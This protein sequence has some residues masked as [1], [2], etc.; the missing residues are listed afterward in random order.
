VGDR[1]ALLEAGRDGRGL[2][3]RA[4]PFELHDVA[5]FGLDQALAA[6]CYGAAQVRVVT[7]ADLPDGYRQAL[8]EQL[9]LGNLILR[10]LGYGEQRLGLVDGGAIGD[11]LWALP[12]AVDI[13]AAGFVFPFEKRAALDMALGHLAAAAPAPASEPIALPP[14]SP[15]GTI[16]VDAARCTLCMSCVGA[17]PTGALLDTPEEPKLRFVERNCVQCGLCAQTCPE[18]AITLQAQLRLDDEARRPRTLNAAEPFHCVSCGKAFGT[19][20]MI[21]NMTSRLSAHS[22][23][24]GGQALR[25]L[26]MCADCRVLDLMQNPDELS[27]LGG[28]R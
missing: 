1:D 16:A 7:A 27:V 14:R 12:G 18:Q 25:R 11:A 20:Q 2:P 3:A 4:I 15:F 13:P 10:A 22:M 23:F 8:Q 6:L 19:R 28:G 24:A 9:A 26:Q 17:C 21:D 5:S